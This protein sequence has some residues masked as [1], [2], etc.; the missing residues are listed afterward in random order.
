METII[1]CGTPMLPE[2]FEIWLAEKMAERQADPNAPQSVLYTIP[3]IVH[4]IHNG[5]A[6]GSGTNISQNK[7]NSQFD[8][9]NEDFRKTNTDW[10][11]TPSAWQ[12]LVADCEINFCKAM[13]DPQGNALSEPGIHRVNRNTMGWTAP[14]YSSSYINSTIKPATIWDPTKYLNIWVMN[15]SG[16][17][18][19]YATFPAGSGLTGLSGPFGTSTTDG[20][21]IL[22][23]AFG[24]IAPLLAQYNKGRT[25]T[26]EIGH[27][28]GL[29]HIWGDDGNGNGACSNTECSGTD[30]VTDTPNQADAHFGCIA[31]SSTYHANVCT[32]TTGEMTMNYMDYTDDACMYMFT[33]GQKA[34]MQTC[35]ANGTYR[36]P[37]AT[38]NGCMPVS[39][40]DIDNKNRFDLFP[41]PTSGMLTIKPLDQANGVNVKIYNTIGEVIYELKVANPGDIQID[42]S[43]F[44]NGVYYVELSNDAGKSTQKVTVAK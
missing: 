31:S 22:Y 38:S 20:V 5:E 34:R 28:L 4:V 30:Y 18:L 37:L 8:I 35:M 11:N 15:L 41:N 3:T 32:G 1:R 12:S 2:E 29:R 40:N 7:V 43:A 27:W 6:V 25:A 42:L 16:G 33:A 9:L 17:L 21:V 23:T 44:G 19:G 36:A 13:R 24:D 14:P 39:V 10:T 26:H